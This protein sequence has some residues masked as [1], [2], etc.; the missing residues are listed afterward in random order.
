MNA[1]RAASADKWACLHLMSQGRV[2]ER[3]RHLDDARLGRLLHWLDVSGLA[4][5]FLRECDSR[6]LTGDI[7]PALIAQ[8]RARQKRN[9]LRIDIQLEELRRVS[10]ALQ[11]ANIPFAVRKGFALTPA[12]CADQYLRHQVDIDLVIDEANASPS[13]A[14]LTSLGYYTD[15]ID[16]DEFL[17]IADS[18]AAPPAPDDIYALRE[19]RIELHSVL[20]DALAG[21]ASPQARLSQIRL[22]EHR[23]G[24]VEFTVLPLEITAVGQLLHAVKHLQTGWLRLSWLWELHWFI[25]QTTPSEEFWK[26]VLILA[27]L[28]RVQER[29][30]ATVFLLLNRAFDTEPPAA[31]LPLRKDLPVSVRSWT[32]GR[33]DE[34]LF[35][36]RPDDH[37]PIFLSLTD[38]AASFRLGRAALI[39]RLRQPLRYFVAS[40][41]RTLRDDLRR[42][43]MLF[44][45]R[46][47]R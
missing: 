7:L 37:S 43:W 8:L 24:G 46:W 42:A 30:V 3:L 39:E 10:E 22:E 38:S 47:A 41:K 19:R 20:W 2:D 23:V 13:V 34:F 28:S 32:H 25:T 1:K 14:T 18:A 35:R 17:L 27:Q 33:C 29:G 12:F 21:S 11:A 4:L 31:V 40:G 15:H 44:A 6:H 16:N 9:R 45:W 26:E 5:H 36:E